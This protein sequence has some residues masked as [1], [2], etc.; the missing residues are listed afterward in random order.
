MIT[1]GK[2]NEIG[3]ADYLLLSE[4]SQDPTSRFFFL[5][6]L[7]LRL[8]EARSDEMRHKD[9]RTVFITNPCMLKRMISS[10]SKLL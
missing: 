6:S 7:T 10:K 1:K 5:F 4:S 3:R 8:L 9:Q 2:I